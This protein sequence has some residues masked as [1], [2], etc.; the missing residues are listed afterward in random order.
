[1][2][3]DPPSH[4]LKVPTDG[5]P[6]IAKFSNTW[7]PSHLVVHGCNK[8]PFPAQSSYTLPCKYSWLFSK[9]FHTEYVAA[10]I[11]QGG[12]GSTPKNQ[13]L[14]DLSKNHPQTMKVATFPTIS[15]PCS[16]PD[17]YQLLVHSHRIGWKTTNH[18]SSTLSQEINDS[19]TKLWLW[20]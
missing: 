18:Y 6:P 19:T 14:A 1:M 7:S 15:W 20:G 2:T 11:V 3:D 10:H 9:P 13:S 16:N 8:Q 4:L 17:I 5:S 12:G